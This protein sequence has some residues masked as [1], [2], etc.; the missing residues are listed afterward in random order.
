MFDAKTGWKNVI[1]NTIVTINICR[2]KF[3]ITEPQKLKRTIYSTFN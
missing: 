3:E 2:N 1:K